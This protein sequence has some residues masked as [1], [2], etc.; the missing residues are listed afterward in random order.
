MSN[1]D[2][3]W[4]GS[5]SDGSGSETNIKPNAYVL[6]NEEQVLA[7]TSP[8]SAAYD[9]VFAN[10]LATC[11][12]GKLYGFANYVYSDVNKMSFI[13]SR[14]SWWNGPTKS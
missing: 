5:D 4:Y 7:K 9:A 13:G 14:G 12:N 10:N 2:G 3:F 11:R 1:L 8:A 6:M